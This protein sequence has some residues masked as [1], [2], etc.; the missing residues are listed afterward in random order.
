MKMVSIT[1]YFEM[2]DLIVIQVPNDQNAL[3]VQSI[4]LIL[5]RARRYTSWSLYMSSI[6][7]PGTQAPS[8]KMR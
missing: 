7:E 5:R 6:R 4:H 1:S 8:L 2:S 3:I